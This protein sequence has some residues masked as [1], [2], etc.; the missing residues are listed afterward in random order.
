MIRTIKTTSLMTATGLAALAFMQPAVA[1]DAQTFVD[2]IE[3]V[4]AVMGYDMSFGEANLSGDTITVDGVT[5]NMAGMDPMAFDAELTFSGV[6]EN[7]DGSY[8]ADS[9]TTPDL[10]LEF[11]DEHAGHLTLVDI[12]AEDLWLPPEGDTSAEALVQMIGRMATGPLT[13][14]RD[15]A[16]VIKIAGMEAV[17]EFAYDAVETLESIN[18]DVAITDIWADLSTLG[19]E[20]PEAGAIVEALGLTRISGNLTQSVNWSMAG[21]I[22]ER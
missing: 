19:E 20:E 5:I 11:G 9:L 18:S 22:M 10:D 6:V 1:L 17:S 14:T 8:F 4:Y 16:E 12:V 3:A 21:S 13:V 15:G 2:R 7:D